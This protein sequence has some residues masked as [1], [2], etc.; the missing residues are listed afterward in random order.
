MK[1]TPAPIEV[2]SGGTEGQAVQAKPVPVPVPVPVAV[3][4]VT[5]DA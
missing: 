2:N 1:I 3:R 4:R 5:G